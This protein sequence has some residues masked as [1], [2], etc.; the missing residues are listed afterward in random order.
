MDSGAQMEAGGRTVLEQSP[1]AA[2]R[3]GKELSTNW[4]GQASGNL[5]TGL[6]SGTPSFR[7]SWQSQVNA[8]RG[9]SRG[10]NGVESEDANEASAANSTSAAPRSR[11][12]NQEQTSAS[13]QA[14]SANLQSANTTTQQSVSTILTGQKM[15]WSQ[16]GRFAWDVEQNAGDQATSAENIG[17]AAIERPGTTN[18]KRVDSAS[19]KTNEEKPAPTT[20]TGTQTIAPKIE[21]PIQI[22][23]PPD[24]SQIL[25]PALTAETTPASE[26]SLEFLRWSSEQSSGSAQLSGAP[27]TAG[28]AAD[29]VVSDAFGSGITTGLLKQPMHA[30]PAYTLRNGTQGVTIHE[31]AAPSSDGADE[32]A[33]SR[34]T[35]A[36]VS[37]VARSEEPLHEQLTTRSSV[38][39]ENLS[40]QSLPTAT[41]NDLTH[42]ASV[43]NAAPSSTTLA[44]VSNVAQASADAAQDNSARMT[45]RTMLRAANRNATGEPALNTTPVAAAQSAVVEAAASSELRNP[46]ATHISTELAPDHQQVAAAH[47]DAASVRDTFSALDSGNPPDTPAWTRVGSQHA[48]AGFRDPALGWVGVRADLNGGGI[49]AT[50]VPSSAEA[51]QTLNGHLAGLSTHLVQQQTPVASLT[52]AL[53]G[54]SGIESGMGQRMQQSAEGNPQQGAPGESQSGLEENAPTAASTSILTTS[55]QS[56]TRDSF[57][58]NAESCGTHISVMA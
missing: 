28:A 35:T 55:S 50:L 29:L 49:H 7:A 57:T 45:D 30:G 36:Q 47:P 21:A 44:A 27:E 58:H 13:A 15:N 48:E 4:L 26:A 16:T 41:A 54:E 11:A 33:G 19:Q 3:A 25:K 8:W 38:T 32:A 17:A 5:A 37:L 18:R 34:Q 20:T 1:M 56:S 12:A 14:A 52:M 23:I 46:G 10:T 51:A 53:P 22:P 24:Q 43:E 6:A 2:A 9:I 40:S 39:N 31:T 42:S